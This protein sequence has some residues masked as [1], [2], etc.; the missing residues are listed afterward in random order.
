VLSGAD[1]TPFLA[2][3]AGWVADQGP[4][5][6][7]REIPGAGLAAPLTHPEALAEALTEFFSPAQQPA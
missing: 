2:A 5:A 6:R 3:S 4:S 7:I 1:T